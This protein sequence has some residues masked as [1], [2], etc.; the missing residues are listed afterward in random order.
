MKKFR[1][2]ALLL[3]AA[4]TLSMAACSDDDEVVTPAPD[5]PE[6]PAEEV[7]SLVLDVK[8]IT[9]NSA[10]VVTTPSKEDTRYVTRV[11]SDAELKGMDDA[12]VIEK[13][14]ADPTSINIFL[15]TQSF[16]YI[17]L[18]SDTPYTAVGFDA[19]DGKAKLYTTKFKTLKKQEPEKPV[20]MS[21]A[22]KV[23][24]V[25]THSAKVTFTPT[26]KQEKYFGHVVTEFELKSFARNEQEAIKYLIENPHH[27]DHVYKGD[28]VITPETL[29]PGATYVA[30]AFVY[31]D[32]E[33]GLFAKKFTTNDREIAKEFTI[34]EVVPSHQSVT[35]HVAPQHPDRVYMETTVSPSFFDDPHENRMLGAYFGMQNA[36]VA[37]GLSLKEYI[38]KYGFKG[39]QD[40]TINHVSQFEMQPGEDYVT[41]FY[42]VDPNNDDPTNVVDWNYT[43]VRY[44]TALPS[45]ELEPKVELRNVEVIDN[46]N[47]TI[48]LRGVL[49][50]NN[51]VEAVKA[52]V[53]Y[54]VNDYDKYL[55]EEGWAALDAIM[56]YQRQ[57]VTPNALAEMK[58]AAGYSFEQEN[59]PVDIDPATNELQ[60]IVMHIEAINAEGTRV[61]T[62]VI[63]TKNGIVEKTVK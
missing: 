9:D 34:T 53:G 15:G 43:E 39:D 36:A 21:I 12:S 29:E 24:E 56:K 32:F 13:V 54:Y 2:F 44:T 50:V 19:A 61:F 37:E 40:I 45:E 7:F 57:D 1:F 8:D 55:A 30:I 10:T 26:D 16:D 41:Y 6:P 27:N 47:G 3:L 20:E 49:K 18:K 35:M 59:L 46:G 25:T 17:G 42:Y 58:T 4:T 22:V 60:M 23:E 62:G 31:H 48:N 11:F 38:A 28:Q 33:R 52:G 14:L 51:A 63:F 5:K